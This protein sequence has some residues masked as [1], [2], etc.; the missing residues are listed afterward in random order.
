MLGKR[1]INSNDAGASCTTDNGAYPVS[2][3]A[4]YKLDGN[5]L[6]SSGNNFF[7]SGIDVTYPTGKFNQAASFNGSSSY[8]STGINIYSYG[9]SS[10]SFWVYWD[11]NVSGSVI[12]GTGN[13]GSFGKKSNRQTVGLT[14]SSNRFDYISRQAV[15]CRHTTSLS[16]GWHHFA[17]TDDNGTSVAAVDM[18]I[19]GQPVS[20]TSPAFG[21]YSTNTALQIGRSRKN[22]GIMGNYFDGLID[23]VRIFSSVLSATQITQLYSEIQC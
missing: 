16:D 23:Q 10:Y 13:D 14:K 1:L 8:I 7:G 9:V 4:Y 15:F 22:D 5:A 20:F 18:Y 2:N 19:D 11:N 12:G 6:D 17:V 3:L 21:G